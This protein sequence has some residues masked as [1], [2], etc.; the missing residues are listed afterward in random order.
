MYSCSCAIKMEKKIA[1][2]VDANQRLVIE[3]V[4]LASG[5]AII[6]FPLKNGVS[7]EMLEVVGT[8]GMSIDLSAASQG[9]FIESDVG[10]PPERK[11]ALPHVENDYEEVREKI[12]QPLAPAVSTLFVGNVTRPSLSTQKI[13]QTSPVERA[14]SPQS[15]APLSPPIPE[16]P[17]MPVDQTVS[18]Q[19]SSQ[20]EIMQKQMQMMFDQM[21]IMQQMTE[22][23]KGSEEAIVPVERKVPVKK[24]DTIMSEEEFYSTLNSIKSEMPKFDEN[25]R[26]TRQE[27][28]ELERYRL[29]KACYVVSNCGQLFV[30]DVGITIRQSTAANLSG[31]PVYKLKQSGDLK[32]CFATGKLKFVSAEIAAKMAESA[33]I[34][35]AIE[36]VNSGLQA[37]VGADGKGIEKAAM[38]DADVTGTVDDSPV[39]SRDIVERTRK[40]TSRISVEDVDEDMSDDQS[41]LIDLAGSV[42]DGPVSE[43]FAASRR[44]AGSRRSSTH[45][46]I[47]RLGD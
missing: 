12:S 32:M 20:I 26:L 11:P 31:I 47:T 40:N 2:F 10:A 4:D 21:R 35:A 30:N 45:K 24:I 29:P 16:K 28:Q 46:S 15:V 18:K 17:I 44:M 8:V 1:P 22:G 41:S 7:P 5:Q 34:N 14:P 33:D 3:V 42:G 23:K 9:Q 39:S 37:F 19:E 27:C 38:V 36:G 43:A 6:H 25:R 13:A